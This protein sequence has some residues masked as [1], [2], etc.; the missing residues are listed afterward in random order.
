MSWSRDL[1]ITWSRHVTTHIIAHMIST[2]D[3]QTLSWHQII[4]NTNI[5]VMTTSE[6]LVSHTITTSS[7]HHGM[8]R[9]SSKDLVWAS[10]RDALEACKKDHFKII[11]T[12]R[13]W[14]WWLDRGGVPSIATGVWSR[15]N[16]LHRF[17]EDH[18]GSH[19]WSSK[20]RRLAGRGLAWPFGTST[21]ASTMK[22][23]TTWWVGVTA[24]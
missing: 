15:R 6:S 8:R 4:I 12:P 5:C 9:L 17:K 20:G 1:P 19:E 23:H 24:E 22:H 10:S 18:W 13:I 16:A 2:R 3:L 21:S 7:H 11:V 14:W